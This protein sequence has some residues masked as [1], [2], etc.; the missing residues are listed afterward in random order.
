MSELFSFNA[1]N[2]G[3]QVCYGYGDFGVFLKTS[4]HGVECVEKIL[5]TE[6]K[7]NCELDDDNLNE[8]FDELCM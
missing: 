7:K 2:S 4:G 8:G 1:C 6:V 3:L 5:S